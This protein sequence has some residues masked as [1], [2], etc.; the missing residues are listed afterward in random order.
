MKRVY[1]L[2]EYCDADLFTGWHLY[3]RD[4]RDGSPNDDGSWG[5][6]RRG[7]SLR[8]LARLLPDLPQPIG[9]SDTFKDIEWHNRFVAAFV[10]RFP[11]GVIVE[12]DGYDFVRIISEVAA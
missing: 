9:I 2:P 6:L 7:I 5:W 1:I 12:K 3:E 10:D 8:E 4:R 11:A